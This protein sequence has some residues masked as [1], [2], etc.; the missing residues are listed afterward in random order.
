[1]EKYTY[2]YPM[3]SGTSTVIP[4]RVINYPQFLNATMNY[5]SNAFEYVE[6]LLARR[7]ATV[8][9][10]PGCWSLIGGFVNI[11]EENTQQCAAREFREE[12]NVDIPVDQF[13]QIGTHSDPHTDPRAHVF[14]IIYGVYVDHNITPVPQDDIEELRWVNCQQWL[15]LKI[16][17]EYLNL[18]FNHTDL[19]TNALKKLTR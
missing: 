7:G 4:L 19:L 17:K 16:A 3:G 6:V 11:G 12:T 10:F 1:M 8:L 14:N 5:R 15:E 9:A 2:D 18:A 13:W